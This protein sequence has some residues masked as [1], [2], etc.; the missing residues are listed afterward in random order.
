MRSACFQRFMASEEASAR[1][2]P[3]PDSCE[4]WPGK[5]RTACVMTGVILQRR[6][7]VRIGVAVTGLVF[8]L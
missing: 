1:S 7:R 6:T 2:R 4:P 5:S 3:M 8:V